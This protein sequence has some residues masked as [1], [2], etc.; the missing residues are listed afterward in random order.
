MLVLDLARIQSMIHML[1]TEQLVMLKIKNMTEAIDLIQKE[2]I[3][4]AKILNMI[5]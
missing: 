5:V 4:I 1:H 2:V 3:E